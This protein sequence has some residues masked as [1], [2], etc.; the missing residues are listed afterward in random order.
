MTIYTL[1]NLTL[2]LTFQWYG[3]W[4]VV[5]NFIILI[6]PLFKSYL[7]M[8]MTSHNK[9][10]L[11]SIFENDVT[12]AT[13]IRELNKLSFDTRIINIKAL[14]MKIWEQDGAGRHKVPLL[15]CVTYYIKSALIK[16]F[17]LNKI[18]NITVCNYRVYIKKGNP[19]SNLIYRKTMQM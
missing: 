15:R 17:W 18:K 1:L 14:L 11:M 16:L 3:L 7:V 13:S 6:L 4:E 10:Y 9:R 8:S 19:N 2:H 12:F 5:L